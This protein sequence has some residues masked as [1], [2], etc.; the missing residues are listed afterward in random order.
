LR[1]AA[2]IAAAR[3]AV[4]QLGHKGPFTREV[5]ELAERIGRILGGAGVRYIINDRP[6]VA[7]MLKADGVHLGQEDLPPA[8]VRRIQQ[9]GDD[10]IDLLIR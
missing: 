1:L 7:L 6:D 10:V 4:A 5:F 9:I 3:L 8:A 2:A